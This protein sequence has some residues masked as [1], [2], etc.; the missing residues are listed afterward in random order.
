MMFTIHRFGQLVEI[1][2][3]REGLIIR[4][5]Q[6]VSSRERWPADAIAAPGGW[7]T[8]IEVEQLIEL[9]L[10]ESDECRVLVRFD[11]FQTIAED[12]PVGL[13]SAW[14]AHSPFLLKIDRKSDLGRSDFQYRYSFLLAGRQVQV[15]RVGYYVRRTASSDVFVLDPQM[16]SLIEAMD[17][18]NEL[19]PEA[20]TPQQSWLTFAH[21]KGCAKGV[22]ATLDS[23]LQNNDVI[24]PSM[25][26][27]DM[28]EHAD[29]SLSFLPRCAELSSEDFHQV[30]ERNDGAERLY[31]LDRPGL[32]RVRIVLTDEQHEV[33][34]RMKR[35]RRISGAKKQS[36][37]SDPGQ[38]FDG[39]AGNID[40]PYG[41]RVTG[42]GDFQFAPVPR[43]ELQ[44]STMAGLWESAILP[45][46]MVQ[47]DQPAEDGIG[48]T[49]LSAA[50]GSDVEGL[51]CNEDRSDAPGDTSP[52][53]SSDYIAPGEETRVP[54]SRPK[55]YLLI[56]TNEETVRTDFLTEAARAGQY[57]GALAFERPNALRSDRNLHT[58]QEQG[59]RWLQTCSQ[60][61][62]RNGVLL[63]DD[64]GVGKT[65][66]VLTF[67]AWCIESGRFPD[68]SQHEPPFRPILIVAPLILLDTRTWEK[69]METFFQS[70]GV[71]FW[72][73]LTLHGAQLNQ[74]RRHDAEGSE[75]E[76]GKPILDLN[77]IQR[78]RVVITNYETLKNYQHSFAYQR[79]GKSL[80]SLIV[81][82]EAQEYKIP[83]TKIS[84]AIKALKADL[85]IAST[86]TPVENRLLDLWNICDALQPGLLGSAREFVAEFEKDASG[87]AQEQSLQS[88]KRK[89]LF[90]QQHAFLLRRTKNEVANLPAK[91]IIKVDC[92]M[93]KDE[94]EAHQELLGHIKNESNR[95]RFLMVLHR[96]AQ[97][98]QHPALVSDDAE[99]KSVPDLIGQ[100]S[101][102]R[103]VLKTLHSI[104]QRQEKVIVF[105]RH[106]AMQGI[107]AKVLQAEFNLPVRII[108]GET[109]MR[110]SSLKTG[111]LKTRNAI[112][113][114]FKSRPGFNVVIL[115]PF[116]AGI[117]LTIVE[118]NHV[119][120]YGRWWNPAVESQATDRAYRIGQPK[121]VSV[122]LPIL[123]DGSGQVVPS[124]DERLDV[125]MER[126]QRLAEDFLKPLPPEDQLGDE[127]FAD[128]R[129]EARR[130]T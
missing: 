90:Q 34:R 50:D 15:D 130:T 16:Y 53:E 86:G 33:L 72:P 76:L 120:H 70:D 117:G 109:K 63:A 28:K 19:T 61:P 97:L 88:L 83:N 7:R 27:L 128:L 122:Y 123:K 103:T 58:H 2:A 59:V 67:L 60:I 104:R 42:I 98:Y 79:N 73:V 129:E 48:K 13:V 75:V 82:D 22:G 43:P 57:S 80:W 38:V 69:E 81:T 23:T 78:H 85:H 5:P 74:L 92:Q 91:H 116:V 62:G 84:H 52:K 101:K 45:G 17:A 99:D 66:Q 14:S 68:L 47:D 21:V 94:I 125:L 87:I 20:K 6:G 41:N 56:D 126:K 115:S 118:A 11:N 111:G 51:T 30:F 10:A 1:T 37:I 44:E 65:I 89:L 31:S 93:S 24:L 40:L 39:V 108:N 36:L 46:K 18:F 112:L 12:M 119:I 127:L 95:S 113:S 4:G 77:R 8:A 102:L 105:A 121:E 55:G 71:V 114:E 64:M 100:S 35:V 9:G 26:G 110:A 49:S 106:R 107:L 25:L 29:G 3:E 54:A 32:G 124:F 96:F